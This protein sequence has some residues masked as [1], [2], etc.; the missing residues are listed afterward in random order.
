MSLVPFSLAFPDQPFEHSKSFIES[1]LRYLL[2]EDRPITSAEMIKRVRS[3]REK[4]LPIVQCLLHGRFMRCI[5]QGEGVIYRLHSD[6]ECAVLV[7]LDKAQGPLR[8]EDILA[9]LEMPRAKVAHA[10]L[11]LVELGLIEVSADHDLPRYRALPCL[12]LE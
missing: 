7:T 10:L 5:Q 11:T 9:A 3:P 4:M 1:E 8:A 2:F 6:Y 12:L